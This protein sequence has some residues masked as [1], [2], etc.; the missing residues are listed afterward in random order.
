MPKLEFYFDFMS[1]YTYLASTQ[2]AALAE[3]S[4]ATVSYTPFRILD[5]M[6]RV[7]NRP[8]T[9][10]SAAKSRYA[11][12]DLGRWAAR[13]QVPFSP[14]PNWRQLDFDL[15]RRGVLAADQ[16][17]RPQAYVHGVLKAIWGV[18]A[19]LADAQAFTNLLDGLG[20]DGAALLRR[21]SDPRHDEQLERNTAAAAERGAFGS[22]TFFVGD[23]MFFGNDRLD[24]VE[25]ALKAA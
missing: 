11:G 21:A 5:L 17:G 20:L 6:Q 13:Y 19:D 1:P 10:E 7:G 22:P 4:N 3:R 15:L 25:Q 23:Q 14:N 24:F 12:A 9:I 18:S 8:T 16:E 2:I